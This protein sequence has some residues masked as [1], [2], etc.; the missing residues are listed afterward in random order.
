MLTPGRLTLICDKVVFFPVGLA[1]GI[2][3]V[4]VAEPPFHELTH[5]SLRPCQVSASGPVGPLSVD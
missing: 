2:T 3:L 5:F 1:S 4:T